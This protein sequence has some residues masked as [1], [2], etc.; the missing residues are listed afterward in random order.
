MPGSRAAR[1]GMA[2][3]LF[4]D[5]VPA[6]DAQGMALIA[7]LKLEKSDWREL[8]PVMPDAYRDQFIESE[9]R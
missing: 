1:I 6:N 5:G 3:A 4:A 9:E 2:H 8:S 7:N